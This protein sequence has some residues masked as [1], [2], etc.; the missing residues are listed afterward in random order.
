MPQTRS[1][2]PKSAQGLARV[3]D[4]ELA[5]LLENRSAQGLARALGCELAGL[6][7]VLENRSAHG[8][9]GLWAVLENLLEMGL[10]R[11]LGL[12]S[13]LVLGPLCSRSRRSRSRSSH[14][15]GSRSSRHSR[16][17][18]RRSSSGSFGGVDCCLSLAAQ[19]DCEA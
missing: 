8:L 13:D 3:L 1:C 19:M 11:G 12:V 7:E 16:W 6:S 2:M 10:L 4:C 5:G 18:R 17:S 14:G 15:E 9:A